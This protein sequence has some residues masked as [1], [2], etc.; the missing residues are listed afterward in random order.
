MWQSIA[1]TK[2]TNLKFMTCRVCILIA[3]STIWLR[4]R[5]WNP[6]SHGISSTLLPFWLIMHS[7]SEERLNCMALESSFSDMQEQVLDTISGS[8]KSINSFGK[9]SLLFTSLQWPNTQ[10]IWRFKMAK[11]KIWKLKVSVL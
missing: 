11:Q 5:I 7:F 9:D 3:V 8:L 10:K 1:F 2:T 6:C 4:S